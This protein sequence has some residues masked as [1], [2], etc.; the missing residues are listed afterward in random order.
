MNKEFLSL[1]HDITLLFC[2]I[3]SGSVVLCIS[4]KPFV[5][6]VFAMTFEYFDGHTCER[7]TNSEQLS[8]GFITIK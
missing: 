7:F 5:V 2:G 3:L 4:I 8:L 6:S 1:S